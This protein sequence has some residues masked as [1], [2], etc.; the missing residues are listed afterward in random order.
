MNF[1]C[2]EKKIADKKA[3]LKYFKSNDLLVNILLT[4]L[5]THCCRENLKKVLIINAPNKCV[6]DSEI[7]ADSIRAAASAARTYRCMR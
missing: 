5:S 7:I 6:D 1:K 4:I 2:I 3:Y